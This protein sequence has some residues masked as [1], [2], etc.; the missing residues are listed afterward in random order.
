MSSW[1]ELRFKAHGTGISVPLSEQIN[2]LG[3]MLGHV[4]QTQA[5][6][7]MLDMVEK[8]RHLAKQA[9]SEHDPVLRREAVEQ[10]KELELQEIEWLLRAFTTF[11]Y[12]VNQSEQQ[13]IIRINRERAR[14]LPEM[15]RVDSID[16][17]VGILR[18][19]N[20][21]LEEVI[22]FIARLD[23]QPTLTAHPTEARRRTILYKQEHL[24]LLIDK[25]RHSNP[26]PEERNALLY[27]IQNQVGL[28]IASDKVRAS[29][30]T[31]ID[32]V[33]NG[34]HYLRNAIW[35]AIPRIHADVTSAIERHY[36][37]RVKVPIFLQFRSWIGGD[38]DGNPNVTSTVTRTTFSMHRRTVLSRYLDDLRELR[39]D[40]SISELQLTLPGMLY[41]S[42]QVDEAEVNL[43]AHEKRLYIREPFRRKISFMMQRIEL[44]REGKKDIYDSDRFVADL[45]ILANAL[46][47]IGYGDLVSH[48]RLGKLLLQAQAF[49]FHMA[50]LDIRQHSRVHTNAVD[51][52]FRVSRVCGD[53][54]TMTEEAKLELLS[55][56]LSNPRPLLPRGIQVE[57]DLQEVLNTFTVIRDIV[58]SS[59][60][61]LGSYVVSMTHAVSHILEVLLLAK[62]VGLWHTEGDAVHFPIDV[63]PLFETIED[64]DL[65]GVL[66]TKLFENPIYRQH[67]AH[68]DNMQEIMLGYSDSNKDGGYWM[69]NWA[70]HK[71]QR[72]I[73]DICK[74][75]GVDLRL[76]H[77]R[78]GTVGRGGGRAGQAIIA[79]PRV[80]HNGRIRFTE[81]GEVISFR[82]ALPA[83]AHRHLEQ[84]VRAM[85]IA[86]L[87]AADEEGNAGI[88]ERL[89][90]VSMKNYRSL[91]DD[92]D[93]WA[94]YVSCTPI[95]Q[96]SRL[97]I[98]SRPVSRG[99][100]NMVDFDDL[101]A[102]PWG[103]AWTQTRYVVPGWYGAGE[104]L[105]ALVQDHASTLKRMYKEWPF[106]QAVLD[107]AQLEMARARLDIASEYV[108]LAADPVVGKR[109]HD[110]IG[111]DFKKGEAAILEITGFERL[112]GHV[113]VVRKSIR[114]RNPYSDVLNLLQIELIRRSRNKL[115]ADE[116]RLTHALLLSVNGVA[117]AMQST[118]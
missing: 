77:G 83:I 47:E 5:S 80:I 115:E 40:L 19:A 94:W 98:A 4:I 59:P 84:I 26:T 100:V 57:D 73:G 118:G 54:A 64:L 102:I 81:Q 23:I 20:Y 22:K 34:L 62:E 18:R 42:I 67:L 2:L 32:E 86:P 16:E 109:I 35:E 3:G 50:A 41:E 107:S 114:L 99:S 92:P 56:E 49:G 85:L 46:E 105:T 8:L 24:A 89:S 25:L 65:A 69:A 110:Q 37:E 38:R 51:T 106:F 55:E 82:Y 61:A 91:I 93:F 13:E 52:L 17:A 43:T 113:R 30:P 111:E 58:E 75:F 39:R 68:R 97:P 27:R 44:V 10:I 63:V 116:K 28:L 12:L 33:A 79:M 76:F 6:P 112:Y 7:E 88:M 48:G 95:E 104:G 70:L 29:K 9:I 74:D 21:P 15:G 1:Q 60:R 14:L 71:A 108:A 96:I 101:R 31:V 87:R 103:F 36:G 66:L 117:A 90:A 11:F 72:C 53:Y 78:G 45:Q